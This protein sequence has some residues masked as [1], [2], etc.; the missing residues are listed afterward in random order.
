MAH[1]EGRLARVGHGCNSRHLERIASNAAS[2]RARA[3][4]ER[5]TFAAQLAVLRSC[6]VVMTRLLKADASYLLIAK[7]LVISRLLHKALSQA[8]DKPPLV[9]QLWERVLS[10]R[11]R[12]LRSIDRRLA[13]ATAEPLTLVEAMCAYALATSSTPTDVLHHFHKTRMDSMVSLLQR[14]HGELAQ[15]GTGALKLCIHT[16]QDTQAIFPRRLADSLARLKSQP[17]VKDPDVR[18][19]FELN[20]EIHETWIGDEARNYTPWPRHDELQRPDA[21]RILHQW[22]RQAISAFLKFIKMAL[23]KETHLNE[24]ASLRRELIETWILSGSRMAGVKS[25]NV[26]DDLRDTINHH[27][28]HM[29]R[30]RAEDL[31]GVVARLST[32]LES[33]TA[34]QSSNLSLWSSTFP[35]SADL[36]NGAHAFTSTVI[37]MHQ[38]RDNSVIDIVSSFDVWVDTV[39]QVK[40]IIKSM[41]EARWDDTFADDVD[42]SDSDDFGESKQTLLGHDDPQQLEEATQD[43]LRDALQNLGKAFEQVVK[44][45]TSDRESAVLQKVCFLLRVIREIGERIPTL[46]LHDKATA[47]PTPFTPELLKPLHTAL[48]AQVSQPPTAAYQTSLAASP[49]LRSKSTILWEGNPAL[50]TQPSPSAFSYLQRL[51]KSMGTYGSD[52]WAPGCVTVLKDVACKQVSAVFKTHLEAL[53]S[54]SHGAA[55]PKTNGESKADA[56]GDVVSEEDAHASTITSSADLRDQKLKQTCFDILYVQRFV[57]S[58]EDADAIDTLLQEV[59]ME[60]ILDESSLGRLRKSAADYAKKTYLL[61]ALLA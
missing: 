30:T 27:L 35:K 13:A 6:P 34:I 48:A 31:K 3:D 14:G 41:K 57:G 47:L 29:V 51:T 5:Y 46:K 54:L 32:M 59:D 56:D 11:R 12:L 26:L 17:L 2:V 10:V 21:E 16:C 25:A 9:D 52:L 28:E 7:V 44:K 20:L 36:S 22:S 39:L 49:K 61:F 4:A 50:P 45:I 8:A 23:E 58:L 33:P 15:H 60:Q 18:S 40:S 19:L 42:D 55:T 37:N 43:A 38:G 1:V 24:V 53:Q